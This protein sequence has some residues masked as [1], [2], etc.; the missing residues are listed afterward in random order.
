MDGVLTL[1]VTNPL[2]NP[3]HGGAYMVEGRLLLGSDWLVVGSEPCL[4]STFIAS[5]HIVPVRCIVVSHVSRAS[6]LF[7]VH[8]LSLLSS[9]SHAVVFH[10]SRLHGTTYPMTD[11]LYL[12]TYNPVC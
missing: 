9:L 11:L 10:S 3:S 4:L 6:G 7:P 1:G 12:Q 8:P 2:T 5:P